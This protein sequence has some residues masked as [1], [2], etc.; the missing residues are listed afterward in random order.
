MPGQHQSACSSKSFPV[1]STWVPLRDAGA[2]RNWGLSWS[3]VLVRPARARS[4]A[5]SAQV[6]RRRQLYEALPTQNPSGS[7][8]CRWGV[9]WSALPKYCAP[10]RCLDHRGQ[11]GA[12][13]VGLF[14]TAIHF[15]VT[16]LEA[17]RAYTARITSRSSASS[18]YP[19]SVLPTLPVPRGV[20][21]RSDRRAADRARPLA[22]L[23]RV[24]C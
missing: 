11:A 7:R 5:R 23:A 1:R 20:S 18:S 3:V 14:S 6:L 8:T 16:S 12:D 15:T 19:K 10:S 9:G 4:R 22:G 17:L 24:A 13:R 2:W 21:R